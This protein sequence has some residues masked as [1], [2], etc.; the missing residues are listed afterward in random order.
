MVRKAAYIIVKLIAAVILLQTLYF[1]FGGHEES[2][3]IFSKLGAEPWGRIGSGIIELAAAVLLF[4]PRLE[5]T[6]AMFAAGT[7]TGAVISHLTVL[8]IEVKD[9]R[10]T[11]FMLAWVVLACSAIILIKNSEKIA[12][13]LKTVVNKRR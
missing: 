5:W 2:V 1:K 10:G 12:A 11:L 3:Y 7:M 8:G 6:G 9:D 4:I 13:L